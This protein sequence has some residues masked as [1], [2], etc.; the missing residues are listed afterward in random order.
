MCM[1]NYSPYT[2]F[3]R[4]QKSFKNQNVASEQKLDI[5]YRTDVKHADVTGLNAHH[6]N[7]E[8]EIA[9]CNTLVCVHLAFVPASATHTAIESQ[10]LDAS[11]AMCVIT[12][13][14]FYYKTVIQRFLIPY[15]TVTAS[16]IK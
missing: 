9:T 6:N 16:A 8:T 11:T 5:R 7:Q 1:V 15:I 4:Y 3:K 14:M 13:G 2:H 12:H 10:S